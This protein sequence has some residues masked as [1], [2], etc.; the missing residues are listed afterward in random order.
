MDYDLQFKKDLLF[1]LKFT[2]KVDRK[3][4]KFF[5]KC[6]DKDSIRDISPSVYDFTTILES[7]ENDEFMGSLY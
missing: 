6:M 3:L 5:T 2:N 1:G 7:V 4:Q